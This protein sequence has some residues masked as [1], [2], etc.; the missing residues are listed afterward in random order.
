MSILRC[1]DNCPRKLRTFT[2][3]A[4]IASCGLLLT[5]STGLYAQGEKEKEEKGLT[6]YERANAEYLLIEAQKF[7]L[8]ED[9]ERAL[10]FLEQSLKVDVNNHAAYFKRAET[11]LVTEKYDLGI[12]SIQKAQE[13]L[14][15]NKY[16]YILAA[17]LYKAKKDL[18]GAAGEYEKMLTNTSDYKEYLLDLVDLYVELEK[19]DKAL[20]TL[21]STEKAFNAPNKFMLQKKEMLVLTGRIAEAKDYLKTLLLN[22][23]N[24]LELLSA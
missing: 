24:N 16:Y 3:I 6:K 19:Y 8:L 23:Q 21:E 15:D 2:K 17:Q 22:D 4:W 11:Y 5:V 18:D 7:F 20:T 10:A 1:F 12:E 9:Y 13:L 14:P